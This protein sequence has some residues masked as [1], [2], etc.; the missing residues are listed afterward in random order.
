MPYTIKKNINF[1]KQ[2]KNNYIL[3]NIYKKF[4]SDL[5]INGKIIKKV[6]Q[7]IKENLKTTFYPSSCNSGTDAL[8]LALLLD[9][10]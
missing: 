8:K 6:E 4:N 7:K 9:K 5:W 2:E 1:F 10:Q 3:N